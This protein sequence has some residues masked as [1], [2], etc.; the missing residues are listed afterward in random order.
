MEVRFTNPN[1]RLLIDDFY[2]DIP[3][4][5]N[6]EKK[7]SDFFIFLDSLPKEVDVTALSV[8]DWMFLRFENYNKACEK[9][10]KELNQ[11][12]KF[13]WVISSFKMQRLLESILALF[14]KED[15]YSAI[16]LIRTL[17]EVSCF[18]NHHLSEIGPIVTEA[19]K[20]TNNFLR[21]NKLTEKLESILQVSK[22]STRV[23][24]MLKEAAD[25]T[26]ALGIS[27]SVNW[28]SRKKKYE[29]LKINY[30]LLCDFV[31]PN[32]L[33]NSIFGVP[34][35][36]YENKKEKVFKKEKMIFLPGEIDKY[37]KN[38]AKKNPILYLMYFGLLVS[39]IEMCIDLFKETFEEF[40]NLNINISYVKPP[41]FDKLLKL[42][43]DER[44]N[45][46]KSGLK[47]LK[48]K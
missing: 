46:V 29:N 22:K 20:N 2:R 5:T 47:D 28:V 9:F 43:K 7:C 27:S 6:F 39:S 21:Y 31:H 32:Y 15:F 41:D 45:L 4:V 38:A 18:C 40:K 10:N 16:T 36:F 12:I 25:T 3:E 14:E 11:N 42:S 17:V 23:E 30:N 33:S 24:I 8:E 35:R 13:V 37:S 34:T 44:Y 19:N 26:E 1:L 48:L